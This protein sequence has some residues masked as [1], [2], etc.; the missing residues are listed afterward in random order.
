MGDAVGLVLVVHIGVDDLPQRRGAVVESGL[1]GQPVVGDVLVDARD[2]EVPIPLRRPHGDGGALLG[3]GG[4]GLA[5]GQG[6]LAVG[7]GAAAGDVPHGKGLVIADVDEHRL[8]RAAARGHLVVAAQ[9]GG[10]PA[11]PGVGVDRPL[12][13]GQVLDPGAHVDA[14]IRPAD[15]QVGGDPRVAQG[16]GDVGRQHHGDGAQRQ[17]AQQQRVG[18][19]QGLARPEPHLDRKPAHT[20]QPPPLAARAQSPAGPAAQGFDRRDAPDA[21]QGGP[22]GGDDGRGQH[23]DRE[24]GQSQAPDGGG[25]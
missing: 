1:G 20:G 19:A 12:H 23:Q 21:P 18:G 8:P 10:V 17:D 9:H 11:D 7:G 2:R 25:R 24:D 22:R 13:G 6:D 16:G 5:V 3:A 15:T 4:P 14:Q